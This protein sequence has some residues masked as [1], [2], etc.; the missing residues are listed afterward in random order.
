MDLCDVI[1]N[2]DAHD[3]IENWRQERDR[4]E[5]DQH[6]ERDYDYYGPYYNQPL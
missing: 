2:R 5:Q 1:C 6:N 4:V 3:W